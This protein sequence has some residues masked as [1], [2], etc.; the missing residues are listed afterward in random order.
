MLRLPSWADAATGELV[1]VEA[2]KMAI[3]RMAFNRTPV[4]RVLVHGA[5]FGRMAVS[6]VA[7]DW[8]FGWKI[9]NACS[10]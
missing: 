3:N 7:A 8:G 10:L 4:H 6:R 9:F 5:A 1:R 2:H